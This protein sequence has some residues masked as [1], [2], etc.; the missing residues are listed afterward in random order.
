MA[1]ENG[2]GTVTVQKGDSLWSIASKYYKTYGYTSLNKYLYYLGE[3]NNIEVYKDSSGDLRAFVSPG[4][5][6]KLTDSATTGGVNNLATEAVPSTTVTIKRFGIQTNKKTLFVEWMFDKAEQTDHY[7]VRWYESWDLQGIARP[8]DHSNVKYLYDEYT[9]PDEVC[10]SPTGNVSVCIL[11]VSKTYKVKKADGSEEEAEYFKGYWSTITDKV[12][13][14]YSSRS[15]VDTPS[16]PSVEIKDGTLT[17][18]LDD[19]PDSIPYVDFKVCKMDNRSIVNESWK[20]GG[21][22]VRA[23]SA[24][25]SWPVE[26]GYQYK[27]CCRYSNPG[28]SGEWSNWAE[29]GGTIPS[30]SPGFTDYRALTE[31]E[32]FLM[33][34]EAIGAD[35]Y[36]LEYATDAMYFDQS[37]DVRSISGIENT[38]YIVTGLESGKEYFFRVRAVNDAGPTGW[39]GPVSVTIGTEP[40][41]PT[42]WSSTTTVISGEELVLYW[43]HNSE[44]G[45]SQIKAEIELTIDGRTS[46]VELDTSS[47]EDDDKTMF[48]AIN[49]GGYVEGAEILWRVRTAGATKTYG[50]WSV[51]RTVTVYA[52]PTL[53]IDVDST[54]TS[55]PLYIHGDAGPRSQTPIGY[56][57]S[58]KSNEYYETYDRIGNEMIVTDGQEVYS[59]YI[60]TSRQ[61][62]IALSAGDLD[63]Q[64]NVTYTLTVTVSMNSGLT[65]EDTR[66]FTV[67]WRDEIYEP[68]AE[69][70]YNAK[71][72][73]M[74][75]RPY[76]KDRYGNLV[77]NVTLSVYRREFNGKFTEII[78]GLNNRRGTYITDPHPALDM[79][80]YRIVAISETTGSVNFCDLP[81][82]PIGES[83]IIIQWDDKWRTFDSVD[84]I[85]ALPAWSGSK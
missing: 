84:E 2:N 42:T 8:T 78:T 5:V 18:W 71:S 27:V 58:I 16:A 28:G 19:I 6:I 51:Q 50:E 64:N 43:V 62:S 47:E 60:D 39:I 9:P 46:T 56:H 81:G 82:H 76:C 68:N 34:A 26:I 36:D 69:I 35:S 74:L 29:A 73:S 41:A 12:R 53:S 21:A 15:P 55:F 4:D 72:Y 14:Y 75:I 45:S 67:R 57:I 37:G 54:L 83:A 70:S 1:T 52:Q 32:V 40:A 24:S 7:E 80:R 66:S 85:S 49:T 59:K 65:A 48:Y 77:D 61:L 25:Y 20:T 31:T 23:N 30:A 79:A 10:N 11:P 44:D 17:A 38:A 22:V 63:L 33:W 3:I 13:Y